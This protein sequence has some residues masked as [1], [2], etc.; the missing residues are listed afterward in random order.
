MNV[1][2]LCLA[3]LSLGPATGYEIKKRLE[4][5][6][7]DIHD[8]SLG[9]IYPA[10]NRLTAEAL[11]TC[12][13]HNQSKRPDKKVYELTQVGKVALLDELTAE[14]PDID[15]VRSDFLVL[16]LFAHVLPPAFVE[17]AIDRRLSLYRRLLAEIERHPGGLWPARGSN[18]AAQ[19]VCGYGCAVIAASIKFIEENRHLVEAAALITPSEEKLRTA[20]AAE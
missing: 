9:S 16:M 20:N 5:P 7:H 2:S 13:E 14:I 3:V 8:A 17:Q 10:L 11:V 1:R 19:F 15:R 12:T 18:P 4:G 6:L